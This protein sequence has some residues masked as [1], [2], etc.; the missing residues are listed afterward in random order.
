VHHTHVNNA[1]HRQRTKHLLLLLLLLIDLSLLLQQLGFE[2]Y[3]E[4]KSRSFMPLETCPSKDCGNA[5]GRYENNFC[6]CVCV[7]EERER[8][9]EKSEQME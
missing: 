4:V 3:H 9:R 7:C 5:N 2:I 8:E 1:V 6:A